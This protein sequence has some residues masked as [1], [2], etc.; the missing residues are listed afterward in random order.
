MI[1][2]YG[3]QLNQKGYHV[4]ITAVKVEQ[5][6]KWYDTEYICADIWKRDRPDGY[7]RT[8]DKRRFKK[9][10]EYLQGK[11]QIEE[12]LFPNS[13]ILNVRQKCIDF[14]PFDKE[15]DST[16]RMGEIK[17]N[18]ENLPFYEVDGQ[19]RI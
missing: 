7:Q 18:E 14:T 6:K 2:L 9:I 4:Y 10:A 5:I 15:S 13:I 19:H 12:T 8:P 17:I 1:R 16:I 11:L 3:I